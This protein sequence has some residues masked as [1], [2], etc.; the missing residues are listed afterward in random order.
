MPLE[1]WLE[2]D[3]K[4]PRLEI[5]VLL[6]GRKFRSLTGAEVSALNALRRRSA[7]VAVLS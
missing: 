3:R 7:K 4:A 6:I 1:V 2:A 5:V